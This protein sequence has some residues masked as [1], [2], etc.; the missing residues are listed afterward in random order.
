VAAGERIF[1]AGHRGMVGSAIVRALRA[2]GRSDLVLVGRDEADLTNQRA[3]EALFA[4]ERPT[5]VVLAAARVGGIQANR[6][7]PGDFLFEN[8]MI[9]N[10]V[11][12][13]ARLHGIQQLVFLASSCIYPRECPQP[14]REEYMFTGPLEPTNEGYAIA[15]LAG[16][17]LAQFYTQQYG[18]PTLSLVPCNLY[19]R[20]DTFDLQKSHVISALVR[21]FVDAADAEDDQVVM[22]GTGSA[23]REF[24]HVDDMARATLFLMEHR[25]SPEII[26]VGTGTDVSI[27]ELAELVGKKAGY[28]GR[29]VWDAS[30]PDGMPRKCMDVSRLAATGF[31]PA[32]SLD[33]GIEQVISEYRAI[34]EGALVHE[35]ASSRRMS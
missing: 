35:T 1:V 28:H 11:I 6:T 31:K 22:W 30:M 23:R 25:D 18:L 10:N 3:V 8:L 2:A 13:Q 33:E 7:A 27:R 34:K 9:Q 14:M 20:N 16:V 5:H 19:G 17:R 15:K 29:M 4:R 21:K 26:N 12:H 24:M 32:I